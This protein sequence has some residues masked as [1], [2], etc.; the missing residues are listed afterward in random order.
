MHRGSPRRALALAV[1]VLMLGACASEPPVSDYG[2]PYQKPEP[3][4]KECI[5]VF[6]GVNPKYEYDGRYCCINGPQGG[7]GD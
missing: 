3:E 6:C 4:A 1:A 7:S 5:Y 2:P